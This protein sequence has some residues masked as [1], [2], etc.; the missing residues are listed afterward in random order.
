MLGVRIPGF[1]AIWLLVCQHVA[2]ADGALYT[3]CTVKALLCI[4][5]SV[6]I[7]YKLCTLQIVQSVLFIFYSVYTQC[8]M[9]SVYFC[10]VHVVACR[11]AAFV[12]TQLAEVEAWSEIT[13]RQLYAGH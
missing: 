4:L 6:Y 13:C 3:L 1:Q 8:T 11:H 10:T 5:Y 12:H 2:T 9:H 7:L